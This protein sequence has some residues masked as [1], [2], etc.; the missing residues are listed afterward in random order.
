MVARRPG[1]ARGMRSSSAPRHSLQVQ[2]PLRRTTWAAR[3]PP[4]TA[5]ASPPEHAPQAPRLGILQ[6]L[7]RRRPSAAYVAIH[8][9]IRYSPAL[10][11]QPTSW[12]YFPHLTV[13]P[14]VVAIACAPISSQA[15]AC[16]YRNGRP[17]A[18]LR[19]VSRSRAANVH[20]HPRLP[21]RRHLPHFYPAQRPRVC[22]RRRHHCHRARLLSPRAAHAEDSPR[23]YSPAPGRDRG[24][25]RFNTADIYSRGES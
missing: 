9:E 4:A 12:R 2:C 23:H 11:L 5:H 7:R 25:P 24:I 1:D 13:S 6:K 10:T 16:C 17:A 18:R 14:V 22:V 20:G 21:A 19:P 8:E 3:P 15:S